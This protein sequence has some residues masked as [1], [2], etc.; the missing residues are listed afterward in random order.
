MCKVWYITGGSAA[1]GPVV[2]I[3]AGGAAGAA[4]GTFNATHGGKPGGAIDS[5]LLILFRAVRHGVPTCS[6]GGSGRW[7]IG[8]V[9]GSA[10]RNIRRATWHADCMRPI[11]LCGNS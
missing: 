11:G 4:A 3:A 9:F 10:A 8:Q 1:G 6:A 2:I 5:F 7:T